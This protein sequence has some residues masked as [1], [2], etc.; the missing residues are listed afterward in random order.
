MGHAAGAEVNS[1][2]TR[3]GL[4][5]ARKLH[6]K[7]G[8]TYYL[9]SR[10]LPPETRDDVDA[11]YGFVRTADEWVDN[12]EDGDLAA[13]KEKVENWRRAMRSA[14][15]GAVPDDPVLHAFV[16]A[17][18]RHSIPREEP[19]LFLDAMATDCVKSAYADY[20]ELRAYMRG[21]AA[22]VGIMLGCVFGLDMGGRLR[23]GAVALAEAMQM[24]NFLRDVGEDLRRGRVYLPE[25]D[26]RSHGVDPDMLERGE[27]TPEFCRLMEALVGRTRRL[28]EQSDPA[29]AEIPVRH[30]R[31][32][33]A[34]RVLYSRILDKIEENGYDVFR[35]RARTSRVEKAATLL[36]T[37]AS[38]R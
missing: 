37:L 7:H 24:T 36:A 15:S 31:A 17:A 33:V 23:E 11:L 14:W 18:S 16:E 1:Q 26:M 28:Y 9:S 8:T 21:S 27:A 20:G 30:R 10:L 3:A 25:E 4:A 5:I 38:V 6:R 22:S 19:E 32:V 13:A 2:G 12:P 34:A 29:I 35:V